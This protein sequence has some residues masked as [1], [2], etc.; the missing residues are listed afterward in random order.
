MHTPGPWIDYEDGKGE[1]GIYI[2]EDDGSCGPQIA[3]ILWE[4]LDA[5]VCDQARDDAKLL[6]AAPDLLSACQFIAKYAAMRIEKGDPLPPQL[7]TAVSRA[8]AISKGK[9]ISA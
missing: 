7:T 6:A 4:N 8:I 2:R 3:T 1:I 9:P 5:D